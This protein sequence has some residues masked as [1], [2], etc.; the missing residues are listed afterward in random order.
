VVVESGDQRV[1]IAGDHVR[2]RRNGVEFWS[3]TPFE[4][5]TEMT[6]AMG[7]PGGWVEKRGSGVVVAC[8]GDRHRGYAVCVLFLDSVPEPGGP[9]SATLSALW[10]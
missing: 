2:M 10:S 4:L 5:W 9:R 1:D 6:V 8:E 7:G 3:P